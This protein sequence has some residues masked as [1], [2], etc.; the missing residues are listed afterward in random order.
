MEADEP[1]LYS[2]REKLS[3]QND[4]RLAAN[5]SKSSHEISF[6]PKY[7]DL[8]EKKPFGI[9]I[10]PLLEYANIKHQNN[11]KAFTLVYE[12]KLSTLCLAF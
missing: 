7:V 2:R 8:Y 12:T 6:P 5:P 1:L 11:E 3:L 9:R 4:I 10:S